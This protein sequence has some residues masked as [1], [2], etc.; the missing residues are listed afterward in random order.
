[1]AVSYED[2]NKFCFEHLDKC[3]TTKNGYSWNARCPFCGDSKKSK[4]KKRFYIK[5]ENEQV[6]CHCFNC[7]TACDFYGLYA[8]VMGMS[9]DEAVSEFRKFDVSRIKTKFK[10]KEKK[11][12]TEI[13]Y[14]PKYFD[15]IKDE[16]ITTPSNRKEHILFQ[17]LENFRISRK[18]DNA[19]PLYV[20]YKG[21]FANR[22][23]VPVVED[24][25]IIYF[26]GRAISDDF[27][28]KYLNPIA[29]KSNVILNKEHFN[30]T[31]PIIIAEGLIDAMS[32]DKHQAT[33]CLGASIS[34]DFLKKINKYTESG[35]IIALDNPKIDERARIELNKILRYSSFSNLKFFIMPNDYKDLNEAKVKMNLESVY[36]FVIQNSFD[37]FK[38]SLMLKL[39]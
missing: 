10:E 20:S 26:Q 36:D 13:K 33:S 35:L 32:V 37:S 19:Y 7:G 34:D 29:E 11:P 21:D 23:I 16:C 25:H 14:D 24:E 18:I 8:H 30:K 38:T 6:V 3:E 2:V 15:W 5:F 31:E 4:F 12:K 9:R 22:I 17:I 39:K 28:P 27:Y 1:M